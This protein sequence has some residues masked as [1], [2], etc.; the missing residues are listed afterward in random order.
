MIRPKHFLVAASILA[1]SVHASAVELQVTIQNLAPQSPL[2]LYFGPVWLGFHNGSFDLFN[3]GTTASSAIEPLAEL[4]DSSAVNT[5]FT[6]TIPTGFSTVLKNPGGPGPGLFSPGATSSII[7]NIDPLQN[8]YL[9]F[10]TMVVPSN[11]SFFANADPLFAQLFDAS[12]SFLGAQSWTLTGANVW[13]AGTEVNSP[14][15]GGVF[16]AGVDGTLGSNEGGVIHLQPSN[17][18]DNVIGLTN[19]AGTVIG[20]GLTSNPFLRITVSAV[21]EPSTY[22]II[23]GV[24]LLGLIGLRRAKAR[25]S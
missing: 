11:D 1:A 19:G 16:V 7:V 8:R 15:N 6:S 22:G 20:Q 5:L 9:S 14:L 12:G 24:L 4:G 23:G 10:G 3:P 13:D 2:G 21:P 17:G 25:Q 18:L